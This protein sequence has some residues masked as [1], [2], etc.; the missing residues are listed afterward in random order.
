MPR[1]FGLYVTQQRL[2]GCAAAAIITHVG[3][4]KGSQHKDRKVRSIR[5]AH[6]FDPETDWGGGGICLDLHGFCGSKRPWHVF[7][8]HT[9]HD[10]D[11]KRLNYQRK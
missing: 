10:S 9:A 4:R 5:P 1:Y 6:Y 8:A 2:T 11:V 7:S 3:I